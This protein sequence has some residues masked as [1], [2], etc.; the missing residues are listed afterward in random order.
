VKQI[1]V[2]SDHVHCHPAT[3]AARGRIRR[4]DG[5]QV[6]LR[7]AH[8]F[9]ESTYRPERIDGVFTETDCRSEAAAF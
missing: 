6:K 4:S 5:V 3:G 1:T 7:R 2:P 9:E 8:R